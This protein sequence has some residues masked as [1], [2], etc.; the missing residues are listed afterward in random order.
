MS[1]DK[2][3]YLKAASQAEKRAAL[4]LAQEIYR[5]DVTGNYTFGECLQMAVNRARQQ[6]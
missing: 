1:S 5:T 4:K 6:A 2:I 3:D